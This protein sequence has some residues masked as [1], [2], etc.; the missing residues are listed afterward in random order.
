M[1]AKIWILASLIVTPYSFM[2]SCPHF[3]GIYHLQKN[4]L[5]HSSEMVVTTKKTT[6]YKII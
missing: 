4:T 2:G 3:E 6:W 5:I 1:A